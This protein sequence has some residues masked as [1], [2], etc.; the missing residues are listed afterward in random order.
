MGARGPSG[1]SAAGTRGPSRLSVA[2][3]ALEAPVPP[4]D[5]STRWQAPAESQLCNDCA[6]PVIGAPVAANA[7]WIQDAA[8]SNWPTPE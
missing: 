1:L 7:F 3:V 8:A 6:P 2:G 5:R 4:C